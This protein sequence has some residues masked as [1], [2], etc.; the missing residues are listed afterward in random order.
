MKKHFLRAAFLLAAGGWLAAR[1]AD[2]VT[3]LGLTSEQVQQTAFTNVTSDRLAA[4]FSSKVRQLAKNI[5]DGSRVAA[6]QAMGAVVKT[7]ASSADFKKRYQDWLKQKY[8]I[9]DEKTREAAQAQNTSVGDV[10]AVYNQQAA[11]IQSSYSQMPPATL[12]MMIQSQIQML[13]QELSGAEGD[14]KTTK[15]KELGELKR[16]QTLSKTNP[17]EFKKQYIANFDKMLKQ[18]MAQSRGDMEGKLAESKQEA[19]DY[20][21]RL[22]D[23]KAAPDLNTALKQ[24]LNDFIAL[25]GSVDFNAQLVQRGSKSEF[26][27]PEYRNKPENWKLL[28]RMG[29]EPVQAARSFAQNWVK[30]LDSKK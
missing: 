27:N 12:A 14:D 9:S 29:K 30:E 4:P 16:I 6:V 28:F 1:T 25:A 26:A 5:P 18:Q 22:A 10:Q 8:G 23:Y 3:D 7:Y 20:Q 19:A 17:D 13:Q 2:I 11:M 15:T 24:R 21:K